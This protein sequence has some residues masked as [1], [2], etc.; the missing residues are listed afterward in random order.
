MKQNKY[1]NGY[2]EKIQ[3]W[4][5]QLLNGNYDRKYIL[6]KIEYFTQREMYRLGLLPEEKKYD[7]CR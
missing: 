1:P 7:R 6:A 2:A 3:F 5:N 4:A